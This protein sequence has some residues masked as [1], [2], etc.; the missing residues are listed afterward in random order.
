MTK[1]YTD[2]WKKIFS[3]KEEEVEKVDRSLPVEGPG[4]HSFGAMS[5][6]KG[7]DILFCKKCGKWNV[8]EESECPS[9]RIY[10][11]LS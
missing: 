11:D 9:N 3:G 10:D 2:N 7:A 5:S 4:R 6:D 1:R 8:T